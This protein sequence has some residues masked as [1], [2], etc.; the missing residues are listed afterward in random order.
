[1]RTTA[2]A[3]RPLTGEDMEHS[4]VRTGDGVPEQL[5]AEFERW[6]WGAFGLTWIWG[7]ANRTPAA[8]FVLVPF[9]GWIGMPFLLGLKG[10]EWAWRNGSWP[11]LET[12]RRVQ[13]SWARVALVA[14]AGVTVAV[15]LIV[16]LTVATLER[17]EP[18]RLAQVE[19]AENPALIEQLGRP[20]EVGTPTGSLSVQAGGAGE[21]QLAFSV[22]GP[23][24][25]GKAYVNAHKALG[26]WRLQGAAIELD[27]GTRLERLLSAR[28][29]DD[30]D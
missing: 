12:F 24:G 23:K 14:W 20:I 27:N 4:N 29:H 25:R 28:D 2:A 1:M 21:A 30:S 19:L 8:W 26:T 16:G 10:N 18:F 11:D 3:V 7:I 9:V 5:S 13:R 22:R 6:N 15:I 17:S